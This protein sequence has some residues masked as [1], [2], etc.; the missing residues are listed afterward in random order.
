M[1]DATTLD[2]VIQ[3]DMLKIC[4]IHHDKNQIQNNN[5]N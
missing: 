1:F 2:N 3:H 4:V 5:H